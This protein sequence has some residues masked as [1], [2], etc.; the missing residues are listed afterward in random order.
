MTFQEWWDAPKTVKQITA[1]TKDI[2][3]QAYAAGRDELVAAVR[4]VHAAKGR[5][6]SQL[7]MCDLYNLCVLPHERPMK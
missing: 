1:S 7:A 2:A 3:Q 6:H 4:K 5:Y